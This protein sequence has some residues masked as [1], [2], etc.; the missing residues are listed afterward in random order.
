MSGLYF[1]VTQNLISLLRSEWIGWGNRNLRPLKLFIC[2]LCSRKAKTGSLQCRVCLARARE[3]WMTRHSLFCAECR[4]LIKP[5]ERRDGKRFHK[6]CAQK[7]R[8]T[9]YPQQHRFA[10]LAYQ[11][12]HRE[13]GLCQRCPEKIF[14]WGFCRKH[15]RME[16][17]KFYRPRAEF[18][19]VIYEVAMGTL[20]TYE[21]SH[22]LHLSRCKQSVEEGLW[23]R[24]PDS[25][26]WWIKE[27]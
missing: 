1:E 27:V 2:P 17:E 26:S 15:Y 18:R 5:E 3:Q 8:A 11:R 22:A 20:A 16:Q 13:L 6:R 14:R 7:R 9:K 4:K 23:K 19:R 24:C 10:S 25:H 21:Q 12:R